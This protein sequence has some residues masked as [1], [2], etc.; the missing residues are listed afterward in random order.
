MR[1]RD[2]RA[3]V[4]RRPAARPG[5]QRRTSSSHPHRH[6]DARAAS[7]RS[8]ATT[9]SQNAAQLE[10]G[11]P[12]E[13]S[14]R[15]AA[16]T[17]RARRGRRACRRS[18]ARRGTRRRPSA[19]ARAGRSSAAR[20]RRPR[21]S[22]AARGSRSRRP[23]RA[24]AG[25]APCPRRGT[26]RACRGGRAARRGVARSWSSCGSA[27][28]SFSRAAA[29]SPPSPSSAA[30]PGMPGGE[31]RLRLVGGQPG[32]A[33][34]V[35][36]REPVAARRAAHRLD[37]HA[38]GGERLDVAVHGAHRDLELLGELRRGQLARASGAAGGATRAGSPAF[39]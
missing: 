12:L 35:A 23:P 14:P 17:R 1:E 24:R 36:A 20:R 29:S 21:G 25:A 38:R 8:R 34:A 13:A 9:R 22:G 37:G 28:S 4:R 39:R 19:R 5:S 26:S 2:H 27:A 11:G 6:L 7:A 16:P 30:G 15:A 32:E 18:G 10:A 31:E 3:A 33:R